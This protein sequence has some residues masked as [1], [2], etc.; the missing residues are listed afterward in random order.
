MQLTINPE[1]EK[2]V[3]KL[4]KEQN[5]SLEESIK[6]NGLWIPIVINK[7]NEILDGH[8]RYDICVASDIT[9]KTI[10]REFENEL[11]TKKFVIECNLKRR[12]LNDFQKIELGIPLQEIN[13]LLAKQNQGKRNDLTSLSLD[14]EVKPF[15]SGKETAKEIGVTS[16]TFERGK[17]IIEKAPETIKEDLRSGKKV[18]TKEYQIIQKHEKRKK[19]QEAIK[20]IQVNLPDTI[21]LYNQDFQTAPIPDNSISLIF[22]DPPYGEESLSLVRDLCFHAMKVLKEGGS[23]VFYPGHAHI[24]K[25][26]EYAKEAGLTYHW[27]IAVT[28]SGPSSSIFGRKVL[29]AYKPMLWFTKGRYEGEFVKDLIKSEFQGKE[30]HEWAQSTVESDYYIK[31]MTIENEIVYDPFL[32]SGT[33]GVSA[34]KLNRQ[35]IGCEINKEHFETARRLIS[36]AI[37]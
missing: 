37:S 6:K 26:F 35:F 11:F 22:T 5:A 36:N 27:I 23:L 14:K 32:G 20:K 12:Q 16:I 7:K 13:E 17:K 33:F 8:H 10:V 25:V 18:I 3:P 34:R 28:H 21:T 30:L 9:F 19:R 4:S 1:Y 24:D 29:A 2:L 15:H 31:Y